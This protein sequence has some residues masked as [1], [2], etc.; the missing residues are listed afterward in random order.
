MCAPCVRARAHTRT[1]S[2]NTQS[3]NPCSHTHGRSDK[4][5][6]GQGSLNVLDL[7]RCS[8]KTKTSANTAP[9][10]GHC[11][12][13]IRLVPRLCVAQAKRPVTAECWVENVSWLVGWLLLLETP[14]KIKK[15]N[16]NMHSCMWPH[17]Q[18]NNAT[19]TTRDHTLG[20]HCLLVSCGHMHYVP[21]KAKLNC[22][23]ISLPFP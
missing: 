15:T 10:T 6:T 19:I 12:P 17:M 2:K 16:Q 11:S 22:Y 3:Q 18:G 9:S 1:R 23:H 4:Q 14:A 13:L 20:R 8:V 21:L 7:V 5:G